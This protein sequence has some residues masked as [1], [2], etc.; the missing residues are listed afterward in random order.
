MGFCHWNEEFKKKINGYRMNKL[1]WDK[2]AANI[3]LGSDA[4]QPLE[5]DPFVHLFQYGSGDGK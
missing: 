2:D 3:S 4:K 1:Y 5:Y